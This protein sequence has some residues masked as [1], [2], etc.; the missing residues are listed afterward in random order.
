MAAHRITEGR[1]RVLDVAEANALLP[2]VRTLS[3]RIRRR[4]A[5]MQRQQREMLVL[6]LVGDVSGARPNHDLL[7]LVDK[8]VRYHRLRGQVDALVE[9]FARMGCAVRD[10]DA[11]HVDFTYLREDGLAFLCWRCGED[12]VSHWHHMHEG[13]AARRPLPDA[14]R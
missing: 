5:V 13:H 9:C 3:A 14:E 10:R 6:E 12:S 8:S 7:E 2:A 4:V 1:S 11:S